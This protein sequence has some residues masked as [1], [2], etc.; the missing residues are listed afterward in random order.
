MLDRFEKFAI[1]LS[2]LINKTES[3]TEIYYQLKN[4]ISENIQFFRKKKPSDLV[5]L[6]IYIHD[7]LNTGTFDRAKKITYDLIIGG[8]ILRTDN[9]HEEECNNC[10]SDG[11]IRCISCNYGNITCSYCD[12]EG[13]VYSD[14]D[15][16]LQYCDHCGGDGELMCDE[17]GG[18]GYHTCEIC[19]GYGYY[20]TDES[21]YEL[22][23]I[24]S[25]S[26]TLNFEME[27]NANKP[28]PAINEDSFYSNKDMIVLKEEIIHFKSDFDLNYDDFYCIG[29]EE[30]LDKL[31]LLLDGTLTL[32]D[33]T[34][35]SFFKKK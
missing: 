27:M 31:H 28:F 34:D 23:N 9:F 1:N 30:D 25:W 19:S 8:L 15:E 35:V 22:R 11:D 7:Y 21:I 17:C 3:Y 12:G 32:Y 18:K 24:I 26:N 10:N 14:D 5:K 16:E 2:G 20:D 4:L 13:S 6:I 29:T 33:D